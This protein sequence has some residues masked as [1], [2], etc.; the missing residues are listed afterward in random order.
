[1][2][3]SVAFGAS[4]SFPELLG[5]RLGERFQ[6]LNYGVPGY[7]IVQGR[8]QF[9]A[10]VAAW[11]P[12]VVVIAYGWNDHWLAKGG[13]TDEQRPRVRVSSSVLLRLRLVQGLWAV[14]GR[15][16][17]KDN[18]LNAPARVPLPSYRTNLE[19]FIAEASKVGARVIVVAL[20]SGLSTRDFPE[21]LVASGF[22]RSAGE[23]IRDHRAYAEAARDSANAARVTFVDLQPAF[24]GVE[25]LFRADDIHMTDAGNERIAGAL[26]PLLEP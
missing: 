4:T 25:G 6:V 14:V 19:T 17:S 9:T 24:D 21:Y 23:A 15:F 8:R 3:D 7:T 16:A 13:L 20:P 18:V 12:D 26:A 10:D 2:G 5:A 22:T 1:M 11:R